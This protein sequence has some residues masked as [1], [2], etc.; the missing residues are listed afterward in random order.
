MRPQNLFQKLPFQKVDK[1]IQEILE[2]LLERLARTKAKVWTDFVD[3][4]KAFERPKLC[5]SN[6][7]RNQH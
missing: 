5:E 7:W 2:N 6:K 4:L 1:F 3:D